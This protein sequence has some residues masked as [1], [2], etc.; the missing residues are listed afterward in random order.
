MSPS[1]INKTVAKA[2]IAATTDNIVMREKLF[3]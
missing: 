3:L 1:E 2:S